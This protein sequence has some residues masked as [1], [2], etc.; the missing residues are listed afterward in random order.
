MRALSDVDQRD[1]LTRWSRSECWKPYQTDH[2]DA[3]GQFEMN[4]EFDSALNPAD[5]HAFFKFMTKSIS[6]GTRPAP[7]SCPS[8][9][10]ILLGS[11]CHVH[12]SLWSTK[13]EAVP[14]RRQERRTGPV[15]ARLQLHRRTD[16]LG[17]RHVRDHEPGREHHQ[18][19][20]APPTLS[21]GGGST[22]HLLLGRWFG[23]PSSRP[24]RGDT[25]DLGLELLLFLALSYVAL[26]FF[27]RR[28]CSF[29]AL[30]MCQ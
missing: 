23:E 20:N 28:S 5:K 17:R 25:G 13:N 1:L 19:I 15:A 7:R 11:G 27:S 14:F 16:P 2:E 22:R 21:E 18:R 26:C 24:G 30:C 9:S 6:R 29:R 4:W 8:L 10:A 12:A 3:N